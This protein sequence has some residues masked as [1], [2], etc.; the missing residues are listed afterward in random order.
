VNIGDEPRFIEVP[1]FGAGREDVE[2]EAAIA[3]E[4]KGAAGADAK[5]GKEPMA[6]KKKKKKDGQGPK[7]SQTRVE[8]SKKARAGAGGGTSRAKTIEGGIKS[9][10]DTWCRTISNA[11]N[12]WP[13]V[14]DAVADAV[15]SLTRAHA[16]WPFPGLEFTRPVCI[17]TLQNPTD[18]EYAR[19]FVV[20]RLLEA[21][22]SR[23]DTRASFVIALRSKRSAATGVNAGQMLS[24]SIYVA[25]LA[26]TRSGR[27]ALAL[28][29]Q[30]AL[31]GLLKTAGRLANKGWFVRPLDRRDDSEPGT[32]LSRTNWPEERKFPVDTDAFFEM[33]FD[34]SWEKRENPREAHLFRA[35]VAVATHTDIYGSGSRALHKAI[36]AN[37]ARLY[38]S[39]VSDLCHT[40]D[41]LEGAPPE[42]TVSAYVRARKA[43]DPLRKQFR[44]AVDVLHADDD[45]KKL[46]AIRAT[47][48]S[49]RTF[50]PGTWKNILRDKF[51]AMINTSRLKIVGRGKKATDATQAAWEAKLS[52]GAK[53]VPGFVRGFDKERKIDNEWISRNGEVKPGPE[54]PSFQ[55]LLGAAQYEKIF[56]NNVPRPGALGMLRLRAGDPPRME[57]ALDALRRTLSRTA[58]TAPDED[59][60]A[61]V[62]LATDVAQRALVTHDL[63][64]DRTDEEQVRRVK[65]GILKLVGTEVDVASLQPPGEDGKGPLRTT[66]TDPLVHVDGAAAM[67]T[68]P[69]GHPL[70][71]LAAD[72]EATNDYGKQ[73][74]AGIFIRQPHAQAHPPPPVVVPLQPPPQ[75]AALPLPPPP[76]V[77]PSLQ[78]RGDPILGGGV[79]RL[80]AA[81]AQRRRLRDAPEQDD[82]DR[83]PVRRLEGKRNKRQEP[84]GSEEA[85]D[86]SRAREQR[87]RVRE[88][89]EAPDYQEMAAS[90]GADADALDMSRG[91][92]CTEADVDVGFLIPTAFAWMTKNRTDRVGLIR[93]VSAAEWGV[94]RAV[95]FV[96]PAVVYKMRIEDALSPDK[97]QDVF[98]K[99]PTANLWVTMTSGAV[100]A[101]CDLIASGRGSDQLPEPV[102]GGD[103]PMLRGSPIP[104]SLAFLLQWMI[105]SATTILYVQL[106]RAAAEL[107]VRKPENLRKCFAL[108]H[109]AVEGHQVENKSAI[110]FEVAQIAVPLSS[111]PVS[112]I[113]SRGTHPVLIDRPLVGDDTSYAMRR[114]RLM[115]AWSYLRQVPP[116]GRES[117]PPLE[118]AP[119]GVIGSDGTGLV[120]LADAAGRLHKRR[121]IPP[122]LAY[123]S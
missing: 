110:D 50:T 67:H 20:R 99:F 88:A 45:W 85:P 76:V 8:T 57:L 100:L 117:P 77:V 119:Q 54:F 52:E 62:E 82:D 107:S 93:I 95:P 42:Y 9:A 65:D 109:R 89:D 81:A 29:N 66:D 113:L 96:H 116:G 31:E 16:Q 115:G 122:V 60:A 2:L 74:Q 43:N 36:L 53:G 87:P 10:A 69:V 98:S 83:G 5:E 49:I 64:V 55:E 6:R 13:A 24:A 30:L 111:D 39:F 26:N 4:R 33:L 92:L 7:T 47:Q 11:E 23:P 63:L 106:P 3:A 90:A 103:G 120:V 71:D 58:L 59:Q 79:A 27:P 118:A 94:Q 48:G 17:Y 14:I 101:L 73:N 40:N 97:A 68:L 44:N 25:P 56:V 114:S 72:T 80:I 104:G 32:G 121:D 22:L 86:R 18:G 41:H 108:L 15:I 123:T 91:Y 28:Y 51:T 21:M 19:F 105:H 35:L 84:D 78:L 112:E 70:R 34:G 46:A 102:A 75:A 38:R 1:G 61:T 37:S 12:R